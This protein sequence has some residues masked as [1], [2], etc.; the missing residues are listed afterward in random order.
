MRTLTGVVGSGVVLTTL[1]ALVAFVV[2]Q[3]RGERL[4]ATQLAATGLLL[5][6]TALVVLIRFRELT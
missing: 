2:M 4:K 1:A 5:A 3:A 6:A